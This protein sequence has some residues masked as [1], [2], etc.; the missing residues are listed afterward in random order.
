MFTMSEQRT[1]SVSSQWFSKVAITV[2]IA[3]VV[4]N[5]FIGIRFA[6]APDPFNPFGDYPEQEVVVPERDVT[7]DNPAGPEYRLFPTLTHVPGEEIKVPVQG[8]K[9]SLHNEAFSIQGQIYY[10]ILYPDNVTIS[11]SKVEGNRNPGCDTRKFDNL[12]P[13]DVIERIDQFLGPDKPVVMKIKGSETAFDANGNE[14]VA[15]SWET[16]EFAIVLK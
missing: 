12:L 3:S 15:Q 11:G 14:G 2:F 16:E 6:F 1:S 8:T 10:E 7:I 13:D 5:A 4:L 9:C